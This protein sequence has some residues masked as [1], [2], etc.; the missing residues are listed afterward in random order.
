M[1]F[2]RA[3][4]VFFPL[5]VML[6]L[7]AAAA[8]APAPASGPVGRVSGPFTHDNLSIYLLHGQSQPGPVP[9]T[10][11]EAIERKAVRVDETGDVNRLAIENLSGEEVFVQSGDIVK[12]GQQ[13]RV[14][15][16]SMIL[17]PH[18]GSVDIGS[19]CVEAGRW[20]ARGSEAR[21]YF[22]SS[23]RSAPSREMK[24]AVKTATVQPA[25]PEPG[26]G[27]GYAGYAS[28]GIAGSVD[29][30]A[31]QEVWSKV[32][33]AQQKLSANVGGEVANA[34]S[35]SSLQLALEN[36]K[37]KQKEADYL[38]A[39]A[40]I[41][42]GEGDVIG[43]A[44]AVNGRFNSADLYPSNSLFR[45]MWRKQ[46][47]AAVTEAIAEKREGDQGAAPSTDE[48]RS[49]IDRQGHIEAQRKEDALALD[50]AQGDVGDA[51]R[52]VVTRPDG[53]MIHESFIAK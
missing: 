7:P 11:E 48:I 33:E 31:Q 47:Q 22:A 29:T 40:P 4:H 9:L 46:L 50:L 16:F 32:S 44:F 6:I 15:A 34:A 24:M 8:A 45:K 51:K 20:T 36:D 23:T 10:L 37:L 53:R 18:S 2:S 26:A 17:K 27:G 42:A 38:G 21:S 12:G 3:K 28:L 14:L 41:G 19:F 52:F 39:L 43:F 30:S 49:L 25:A 1:L 35:P 5:V 13:D